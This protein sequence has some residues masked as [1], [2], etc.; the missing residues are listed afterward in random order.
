MN[1][2][3][4]KSSSSNFVERLRHLAQAL[5]LRLQNLGKFLHKAFKQFFKTLRR[6]FRRIGAFLRK[7]WQK[8]MRKF[9]RWIDPRLEKYRPISRPATV[10]LA[11]EEPKVRFSRQAS[12]ED[13]PAERTIQTPIIAISS[14]KP[15]SPSPE[16]PQTRADLLE[17][18][19]SAPLAIFD[20]HERE[21]MTAALNL[22]TVQASEI[23]Q[24]KSKI[25][26]VKKD[27]VLGPLTLD[28]LYRSGFAHFPVKDE[29]GDIIGAIH[30]THLNNLDIRESSTAAE[31]LD[32]GIYYIR[33]DYSLEEVLNTFLRTNSYFFLVVDKFGS[34]IGIL[35]FK[36]FCRYLFGERPHNSFE[37][38]NDNLAVAK[39]SLPLHVSNQ[40]QTW[41]RRENN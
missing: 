15:I 34:I 8:F 39:R 36:D 11:T 27:E 5:L 28:R 4:P 18:I 6:S 1:A 17:I 25:V 20:R 31:I 37:R 40:P 2:A 33:A 10:N 35:T 16:V 29:K 38:D 30:T 19:Q 3:K 9:T 23:M 32:P 21:L 41:P 24:P 13:T 22:P 14:P 26:Y 12:P 7:S